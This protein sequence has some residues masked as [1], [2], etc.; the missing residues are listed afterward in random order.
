MP[1][2][3]SGAGSSATSCFHLVSHLYWSSRRRQK[4][5]QTAQA[6]LEQPHLLPT[7]LLLH[8]IPTL[9]RVLL[10]MP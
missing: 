2:S 4:H 9:L 8:L 3:R 10:A 1:M 5:L 6:P 7:L